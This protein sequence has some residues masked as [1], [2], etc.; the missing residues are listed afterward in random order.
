MFCDSFMGGKMPIEIM[1]WYA[2]HLTKRIY[3]IV[4]LSMRAEYPEKVLSRIYVDGVYVGLIVLRYLNTESGKKRVLST[5][6]MFDS[7]MIGR[8]SDMSVLGYRP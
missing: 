5:Y 2:P 6:R 4:L 3:D 8:I 1:E 7:S